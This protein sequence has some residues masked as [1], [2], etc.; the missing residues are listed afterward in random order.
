[1]SAK[2][3]IWKHLMLYVIAVETNCIS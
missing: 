1:M 2:N 3:R